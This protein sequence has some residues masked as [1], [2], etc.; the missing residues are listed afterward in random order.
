MSDRK[1]GP[2]RYA[3][4]VA[5]SAALVALALLAMGA[6]SCETTTSSD[7]PGG[8]RGKSR[9]AKIGETLT[10]KGTS[11]KVTKVEKA[12]KLG[13]DFVA[14]KASGVFIVVSLTLTNRK[15]RPATIFADN[16]RISGGNGKSYSVDT[17][18]IGHFDNALAILEEIQPDVHERFVAVYDLPKRAVRGSRLEVRDLFSD[19]TGT[20]DLGP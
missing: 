10:L 18:S 5:A 20:I 6:E 1:K 8:S 3:R 13:S 19:S 14:T 16:V 17:D 2:M 4:T 9:P 7:T 15:D 12:A 11:Y